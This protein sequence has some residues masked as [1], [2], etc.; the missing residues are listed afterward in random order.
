[1][2][3]CSL[4]LQDEHN[5]ENG[6]NLEER[7]AQLSEQA[8]KDWKYDRVFAGRVNDCVIFNDSCNN[9]SHSR[10]YYGSENKKLSLDSAVRVNRGEYI[11]VRDSDL[12]FKMRVYSPNLEY[13]FSYESYY[14]NY[15]GGPDYAPSWG[16]ND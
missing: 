3:Y 5:M 9:H 7:L 13:Q 10:V 8:K 16:G 14:G 15:Q 6:K 12:D 11:V 4:T 1:M 2:I